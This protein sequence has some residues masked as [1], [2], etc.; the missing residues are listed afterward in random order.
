M[1]AVTKEKDLPKFLIV[2]GEPEKAS[3]NKWLLKPYKKGEVVKVAPFEEQVRCDKYDH[4][5]KFIKPNNNPSHFR[6]KYVVVYRKDENG[7]FTLK[8]TKGWDS[9]DL[10]T[11]K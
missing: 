9:F 3:H 6:S 4:M 7:K 11:K 1:K 2:N 10:L 8:Y 5:F